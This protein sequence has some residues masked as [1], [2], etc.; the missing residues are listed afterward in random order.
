MKT[1]GVP[2]NCTVCD[3]QI[4]TYRYA[5]AGSVPSIQAMPTQIFILQVA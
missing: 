2:E 4:F 1:T 5:M 3:N